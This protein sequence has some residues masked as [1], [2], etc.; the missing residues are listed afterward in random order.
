MFR[1]SFSKPNEEYF[2]ISLDIFT[3]I[4]NP[5]P[6]PHHIVKT[7]FLLNALLS[8][9]PLFFTTKLTNDKLY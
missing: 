7:P 4:V 5:L 9:S 3:D 6:P 1:H 2:Q 8:P